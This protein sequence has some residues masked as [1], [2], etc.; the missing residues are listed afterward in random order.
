[1]TI[2]TIL[3]VCTGNICRSPLAEAV[4][5]RALT[6]HFDTQDL[7]TVGLRVA[8]AGTHGLPGHPA[9]DEV[10]T[11]AADLGYDLAAHRANCLDRHIVGGASLVYA[12]EIEQAD[13]IRRGFPDVRVALLGEKAIDDP[14]GRDLSE[15]RRAGR[16]IVSGVV[17]R[18]PEMVALAG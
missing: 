7:S 11:V 9:T 13:W 12:M 10:Q 17:L 6:G 16:E 3:F 18:V 1:M 15:Y 2:A 8:S 4:A 5:K 14:Y